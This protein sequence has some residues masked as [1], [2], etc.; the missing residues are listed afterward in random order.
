MHISEKKK[1]NKITIKT[2]KKMKEIKKF[3]DSIKESVE[4][5]RPCG[6]FQIALSRYEAGDYAGAMRLVVGNQKWL[7]GEGIIT[8]PLSGDAERYHE[9]GQL[10][11]KG[12]YANGKRVGKWERWHENGQMYAIGNYENGFEVGAWEYYYDNGQ[13]SK[14]GNYENGVRVGL[15]EFYYKNGKLRYK[16]TYANGNQVGEWEFYYDN[17]ELRKKIN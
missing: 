10:I 14:K 9:N 8:E 12:S 3:L 16:G 1:I 5:S 6:Q 13:M 4:K 11:V 7:L 15:W 2:T 17:G